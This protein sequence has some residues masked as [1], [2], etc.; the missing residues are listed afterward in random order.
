M[1]GIL[2]GAGAWSAVPA[3][4]EEPV[5]VMTQNLYLG[6]DVGEALVLVPDVAAAAQ[7]LWEQVD[8]T[9]FDTRAPSLAADV[10]AADPAVIGLQEATT[11]SCTPDEDTEP[12]A[13]YDFTADYL[14]ATAE[15]GPGYVVA[16]ADGD[17]ALSPGFVIEPLVGLSVVTDPNAFQP[18]FGTDEASCGFEIADALLVRADLVDSVVDV[19][20]VTFDADLELVPGFITVERGYAWADVEIAGTT[21]RFVTTHLESVWEPGVVP[22]SVLQARQL[23]DDL[24]ALGGPLVVMGDFNAD[25]RDPRA[26]GEPNPAAQPEASDGCGGRGC[27]AYWTM[28]DAGYTNAGPDA[29]HPA[30][31]TWGAEA[32][33]AGPDPDRVADALTAG[34]PVGYTERLDYVFVR[35]DVRVNDAEVVG[36]EWP[37]GPSVWPCD[38]PDQVVN[39]ATMAEALGVAVPDG[40]VCFASDHAA[41][42]GNLAVG[43]AEGDGSS[44]WPWVV[45]VVIAAV[46][47]ATI[48]TVVLVRRRT[49]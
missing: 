38:H 6:A 28:I 5:T 20:T 37:D 41:V 15:V 11:W 1:I 35:G 30:N 31:Y 17:E 39:T 27:N 44:V 46:V 42:V 29:D 19:G 23:V 49:A 4:A 21:V 25:P 8:A 45:G 32:L 13:V 33:L 14:A 26:A 16:A 9:D 22:N 34:N 24:A 47:V 10:T 2:A 40:G 12:V 7:L 43:S 36:N 18:L 3:H 48:V